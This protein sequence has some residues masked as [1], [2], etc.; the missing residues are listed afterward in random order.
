MGTKVHCESYTPGYYSIRDM[1]EDLSTSIW[2]PFHGDKNLL[3]GH[4]CEGF[5]QRTV[6]DRYP[7]NEKDVLKVK[8]IEHDT[9]FKNQVY[10]LSYIC[11]LPCSQCL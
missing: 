6:R 7:E 1:N 9:V 4:Y 11:G 8:M 2:S 10:T 5:M 3:N